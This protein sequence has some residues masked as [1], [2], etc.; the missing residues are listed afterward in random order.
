MLKRVLARRQ[1]TFKKS[2]ELQAYISDD[3]L[4]NNEENLG[5][6]SKGWKM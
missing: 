3:F 1:Y 5:D 4:Q 2:M 6:Y